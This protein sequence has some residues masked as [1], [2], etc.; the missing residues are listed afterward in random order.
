M[1]VTAR[2][3]KNFRILLVALFRFAR[4]R[5]YLANDVTTAADGLPVPKTDDGEI[6]VILS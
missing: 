4:D 1:K 2:S 3:R 5:G 6:E